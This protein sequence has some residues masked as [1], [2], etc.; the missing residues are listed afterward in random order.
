MQQTRSELQIK[1]ERV[2]QFDAKTPE[3]DTIA[4]LVTGWVN[5]WGYRRTQR[6][7]IVECASAL[8]V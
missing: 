5:A 2:Q 3:S 6:K 1:K 8:G 4:C 7:L